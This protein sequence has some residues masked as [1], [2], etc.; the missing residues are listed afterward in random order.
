[1]TFIAI[2]IIGFLAAL[3]ARSIFPGSRLLGSKG[4]L[5]LSL[6]GSLAG[7]LFAISLHASGQRL[8]FAP[9]DIWWSTLGAVA[10]VAIAA[11]IRRADLARVLARLGRREAE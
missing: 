6:G 7:G 5:M 3:S 11:V 9:Q 4:L 8:N 2:C 10:A 1:M